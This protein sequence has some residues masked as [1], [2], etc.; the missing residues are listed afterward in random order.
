M[1][2]PVSASDPRFA[3]RKR[4]PGLDLLRALAIILVVLYHA[5]L[6]GFPLPGN[7]QRFGWIG[8]D[9]FFVL[10]GYLIGGQLL[11]AQQRG[12]RPELRRFFRRRA[13]RILPAYLVVLL[14]YFTLP[15]LRE[16][17]AIPPAWKFVLFVQNLGLR[18]GTAFSHAWSL[19]VE[20]QFYLLLPFVLLGIARFRRGGFMIAGFLLLGGLLLR[21]GLAYSLSPDGATVPFRGFQ[22]LIYYATWTRLDPL[23]CGV[24]LAAIRQSRTH[25][26]LRLVQWAPWLWV[27]AL[28]LIGFALHLGETERLTITAAIWQF[29]L[30][31]LGLGMLLVCALSPRLLVSRLAVPGAAFFA[32]IAY[33]VYLSH[34]LVIHAV[35]NFC[36]AHTIAPTSAAGLLLVMVA[37]TAAGV[38]LFLA[39]ERPFLRYRQRSAPPLM[40]PAP[41]GNTRAEPTS[42]PS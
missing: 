1:A 5:G 29:P 19:C 33:S 40:K 30:L 26:W 23:T 35:A 9:L 37:I 32:S 21:A 10:S 3:T 36:V 15:A 34:K 8:V 17:E 31:A 14:I 6:F 27:V 28:G 16:Y 18:G 22:P 25:W 38:A 12:A 41:L 2:D 42:K 7:L 39:V 20:A 13:L 4:Q 24:A 11:A